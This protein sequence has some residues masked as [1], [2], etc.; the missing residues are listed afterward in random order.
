MGALCPASVFFPVR[1]LSRPEGKTPWRETEVWE[2]LRSAQPVQLISLRLG[3]RQAGSFRKGGRPP[4][5]QTIQRKV[6][7]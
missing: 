3:F 1:E 6:E 4:F 2:E 5:P 7:V